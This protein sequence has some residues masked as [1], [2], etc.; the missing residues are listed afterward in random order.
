M[1]KT[2]VLKILFLLLVFAAVGLTSYF[3]IFDAFEL[4]TLDLRF[5][6]RPAQKQN[7][8]IVIIE[9]SEDSISEI[10]RWPFN[11]DFHAALIDILAEYQVRL[12]VF[13][14]LFSD[15][16]D[17]DSALIDST[18]RAGCVY[19]PYVFRLDEDKKPLR[20]EAKPIRE[21]EQASYGSGHIN[22]IR[23]L[24]GKSRRVPLYFEYENRYSP[25]LTFLAVC[26]YL[27]VSQEQVLIKKGKFIRITPRIKIPVDNKYQMM[28]NYAG[29]WKEAFIHYSYVDIFR[30]YSQLKKGKKPLIDLDSLKGKVCFIGLTA[31]AGLHDLSPMPLESGYP[32]VG[33]HANIFNSILENTFIVRVNKFINLI[34]LLA[35][36]IIISF[37]TLKTRTSLSVYLVSVILI[38]YIIAGF[39]L[40]IFFGIWIDLFYPLLVYILLY[41]SLIFLK[42]ILELHKRQLIEK[43]LDLAREIQNG[44]LPLELPRRRT[45]SIAAIMSPARHVGGDL[46]Q[47]VDYGQERIGIA[48][49]DVSGKGVPAALFMAKT[50]SELKFQTKDTI[51][52]SLILSKLNDSLCLESKAGF[53]VTV[54]Y[55]VIDEKERKITLSDGGHL[56]VLLKKEDT[57]EVMFLK[58]DGGMPLGL[59]EKVDFSQKEF[60]FSSGDV[61]V[62]YSDG[63]TEAKNSRKEEF[64]QKRLVNTLK[65]CG[66]EKSS[67]EILRV[68]ER[69]VKRFT[70][71]MPQ[72]DDMTIVVIKVN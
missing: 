46:Y 4:E 21:L 69:E 62:F 40:F 8:D 35:I 66:A 52:P 15:R 18:E 22:I 11:R 26:D 20:F 63:I 27:G 24:D 59:M 72:H 64:G 3:R 48:V 42:Y 37:V 12:I 47:F 45:L 28:I 58:V 53:F 49:G 29:S 31:A 71:K 57:Q 9:I 54:S 56:P 30:S 55:A 6:A 25:H 16:S 13:D 23:D 10:G 68:I 50:I 34:I 33:V 19:Y 43:E 65:M 70:G 36:L 39:I 41:L 67:L 44:F 38:A 14:V 60:R 32:N 17:N 5:R 7:E 61:I 1:Q 2:K 51:S